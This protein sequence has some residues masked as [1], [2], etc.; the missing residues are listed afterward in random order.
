MLIVGPSRET[1]SSR[2]VSFCLAISVLCA[3]Y[4]HSPAGGVNKVVSGNAAV[5]VNA[6]VTQQLSA[7]GSQRPPGAEDV[8]PSYCE[9]SNS[10]KLYSAAPPHP[11][12][13]MP[14]SLVVMPSARPI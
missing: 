13:K 4:R 10:D 2:E 1:A 7:E 5:V 14:Y 3:W 12:D 11:L 9:S 6:M 8:G